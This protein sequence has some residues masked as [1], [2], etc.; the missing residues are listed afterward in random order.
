MSGDCDIVLNSS[1]KTLLQLL[2]PQGRGGVTPNGDEIQA[3]LKKHLPSCQMS[4]ALRRTLS[5]LTW[6]LI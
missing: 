2:H 4:V 5:E 3:S 6:L 1:P